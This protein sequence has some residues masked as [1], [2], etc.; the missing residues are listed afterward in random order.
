MKI[1]ELTIVMLTVRRRA[2]VATTSRYRYLYKIELDM[3]PPLFQHRSHFYDGVEPLNI[4]RNSFSQKTKRR[5]FYLIFLD[6]IQ[7]VLRDFIVIIYKKPNSMLRANRCLLN[8]IVR[9]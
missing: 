1:I 2:T 9:F 3:P 5:K 4:L 6:K 8:L 7:N